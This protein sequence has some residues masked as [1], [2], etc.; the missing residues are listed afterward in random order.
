MKKIF[1]PLLLC[2]LS[3]IFTACEISNTDLANSLEG[4][5]TR[6]VY[7]VGYLDSISLD[8]LSAL[9]N[10]SSYFTHSTLYTGPAIENETTVETNDV[11][12]SLNALS[13]IDNDATALNGGLA[14]TDPISGRGIFS[15]AGFRTNTYNSGITNT[16]VNNFAGGYS[17][18]VV[19]LSLLE[20]NATDLN[21]ILFNISK[22]RGIIM[23]YC[24]DLRSG[25]ATLSIQDKNAIAEYDD[26]IAETTNY[27]NNNTGA[28]TNYFNGISS[29]STVE[30][31][32][33]LINAKLIRANEVLKTRYAKLDT[34]L[35]SMHAILNILI[36]SIGTDY[37]NLYNNTQTPATID[38]NIN[39]EQIALQDDATTYPMTNQTLNENCCPNTNIPDASTITSS[40]SKT[41]DTIINY[42]YHENT[43]P[44]TQI[45]STLELTEDDYVDTTQ[46]E[47]ALSG[48]L[49]KNN[50]EIISKEK[51]DNVVIQETS[52]PNTTT[53]GTI[54]F[55]P[56][57]YQEDNV[58]KP[59]PRT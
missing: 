21:E 4:N 12:T 59:I 14:T 47:I 5:M 30:N 2:L 9:V 56:F 29:I 15:S 40:D 37:S 16:S 38:N 6:L 3:P 1:I 34:C 17:S 11:D 24:T 27:L 46:Q 23:L 35:D 57:R 54:S 58:L 28:L 44:S 36:N 31:S 52:R 8:D 7:S 53:I 13:T 41:A 39:N 10:N 22:M 55:L 20:S 51:V 18:G 50:N 32:A 42:N 49:S 45:P 26:L 25:R 19:D 33:E 48:G 43:T